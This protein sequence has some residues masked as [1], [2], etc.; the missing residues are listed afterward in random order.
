MLENYT[1]SATKYA[2]AQEEADAKTNKTSTSTNSISPDYNVNGTVNTDNQRYNVDS[3]T[4]NYEGVFYSIFNKSNIIMFL[5]FLAIYFVA[6]FILGFFFNKNENVSNYQLRLSRTIDILS[7]LCFLVIVISTYSSYSDSQKQN[8]IE[9]TISN[10]KDYVNSPI[11]I[12]S[13]VLFNLLLTEI[14]QYFI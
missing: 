2:H 3:D 12:F 6:F 14:I 13:T 10:T 1:D 8:L 5:W 9:N 7:L 4:N 11:S